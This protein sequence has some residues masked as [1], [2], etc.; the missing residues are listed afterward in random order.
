MI[1]PS[2]VVSWPVVSVAR[3]IW[4]VIRR[5]SSFGVTE[6]TGQ[7]FLNILVNSLQ[8]DGLFRAALPHFDDSKN[9]IEHL[10]KLSARLTEICAGEDSSIRMRDYQKRRAF[11]NLHPAFALP[12][13][14][15]ETIFRVR[16]LGI[17]I[18]DNGDRRVVDCD[19]EQVEVDAEQA[20][21]IDWI[22]QRSLFSRAELEQNFPVLN[23]E[24]LGQLIEELNTAGLISP[25]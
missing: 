15:V 20:S 7:D 12:E 10:E 9:H 13:R 5:E 21:V 1:W 18:T 16:V 8:D 19:G 2:I 24:A 3:S 23:D 14:G 4:R 11:R 22:R 6:A 17:T 25:V